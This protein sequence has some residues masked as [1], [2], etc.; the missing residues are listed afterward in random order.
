MGNGI[1]KE[2]AQII[3]N[4]DRPDAKKL[5]EHNVHIG[6]RDD[7]GAGIVVGATTKGCVIGYEKIPLAKLK[8]E[9]GNADLREIDA[10][11]IFQELYGSLP[12]AEQLN[13]FLPQLKEIVPYKMKPVEGRLYYCGIEINE[14]ANAHRHGFGFE[15]VS[16]LLLTGELPSKEKFS[17]F[18]EYLKTNRSLP[19]GYRNA[20]IHQFSSSNI[21]NTLQTAVDNLYYLDQNPDSTSVEDITRHSMDMIAKFPCILAYAYQG[22]KYKFMDSDLNIVMPSYD[23]TIAEDFLRMLLPERKFSKDEAHLLDTFLILHAEHG[24]GNNSTFTTRVVSST[25]TDTFS[26]ISSGLASLKGPLHGGANQ[27]VMSMM[28]DIKKNVNNWDDKEE[29]ASYLAKL[30]RKEAGDKSG[31]IYGL[32]HAVYTLSDPRARIIR[33]EADWLAKDRG[34]MDELLLLD[35]VAELA[36]EVFKKVKGSSKVISPNVDFYTGFVLDCLGIPKEIYTPLF[37]MARV[38]GWCAH[39]LEQLVQNRI[40]RPAYLELVPSRPYIALEQR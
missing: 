13:A 28:D 18:S 29:V 19:A 31:K 33:Q 2:L 15:E 7:Q 20:L 10:G 40:I 24:G 32:G 36:P 8:G 16:Y 39:R 17:K 5:K 25:E 22:M 1:I 6:L 27:K 9:D 3:E 12:T 11:K 4:T 35:S 14:I 26:A 37:A 23:A 38:S 21:M 30:I 34:R